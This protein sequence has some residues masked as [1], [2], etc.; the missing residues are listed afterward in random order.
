MQ[1]NFQA[2]LTFIPSSVGGNVV[3]KE[4]DFNQIVIK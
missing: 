1:V 4:D 3:T 2:V